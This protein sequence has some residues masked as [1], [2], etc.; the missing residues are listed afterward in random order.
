MLLGG[1]AFVWRGRVRVKYSVIERQLAA[2]G[3]ASAHVIRYTRL[4]PSAS[5]LYDLVPTDRDQ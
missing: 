2:W 3:R 5:L 1:V 4:G